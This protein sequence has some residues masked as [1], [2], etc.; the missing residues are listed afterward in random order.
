MRILKSVR[1]KKVTDYVAVF[2]RFICDFLFKYF[3]LYITVELV[4][5][6]CLSCTSSTFSH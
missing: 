1:P 3:L 6:A 5:K 2:R 4:V